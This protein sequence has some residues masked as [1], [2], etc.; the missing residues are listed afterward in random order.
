LLGNVLNNT[1]TNNKNGPF[2]VSSYIKNRILDDIE[3]VLQRL[4]ITVVR[5]PKNK[6]LDNQI[7]WV[8]DIVIK[9][10]DTYMLPFMTKSDTLGINRTEEY[11]SILSFIEHP[12]KLGR[13]IQIEGGDIIEHNNNIFIGVNKR[14]R[15]KGFL[16]MKNQFK[17]KKSVM[18]CHNA[19][20]LDCCFCV[21]NNDII[22]YSHRYIKG[23]PK[24]VQQNYECI[25]IEDIIQNDEV[26]VILAAN[27]LIIGNNI[28]TTDQKEFHPFR[29]FLR[30]LGYNV[31][32]IKYN[33]L[34][35][36]GG[37]IRCLTQWLIKPKQQYIF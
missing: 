25:C 35:L 19:L 24:F 34:F 36:E 27:I 15:E 12:I 22:I 9:V 5:I 31:F 3:N 1:T 10:N 37:G 30:Q 33:K 7:L 26:D 29:Q 17:N 14:T 8:R 4:E 28:I 16:F 18:I 11:K 20:H 13:S 21:L 2:Y 32:E 23:L 6:V